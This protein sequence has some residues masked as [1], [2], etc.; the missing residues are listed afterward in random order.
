M[1]DD[2]K[3]LANKPRISKLSLF[4]AAC[5]IAAIAA[6]A[7]FFVKYQTAENKKNA[8]AQLIEKIG[9]VVQLPNETPMAVSVADKEKLSN[10][11][12]ASKV[13]N[14]DVMLIF[15]KAKRLVV[16][17]PTAAKVVDMLSFGSENEVLKK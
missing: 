2:S 12:L 16:Y 10:K 13:E 6:G 14:G 15:A 8:D 11:Q 3:T 5:C 4:L 9:Q 7:Y 17:R 1:T